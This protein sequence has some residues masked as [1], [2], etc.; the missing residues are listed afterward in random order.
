MPHSGMYEQYSYWRESVC[1][2]CRQM[3][4]CL[5]IIVQLVSGRCRL[6]VTAAATKKP[7]T[8]PIEDAGIADLTDSGHKV[9]GYLA[10]HDQATSW[11]DSLVAV[12]GRVAGFR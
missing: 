7:D 5:D 4:V 1:G 11:T 9:A 10:Y 6:V 3:W 2:G 8:L 12:T